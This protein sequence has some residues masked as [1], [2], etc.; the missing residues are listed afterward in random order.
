[1]SGCRRWPESSAAPGRQGIG[2]EQQV[3]PDLPGLLSF[4]GF[5][6][7]EDPKGLSLV[8]DPCLH[9]QGHRKSADTYKLSSI[10]SP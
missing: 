5:H 9:L 6:M 1:M 4:T 3:P 2:L 10:T 8:W 7:N